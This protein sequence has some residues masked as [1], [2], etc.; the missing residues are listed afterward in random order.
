MPLIL[1]AFPLNQ[2]RLLA[3]ADGLR[4]AVLF[5]LALL[6]IPVLGP[7]GAVAAKITA[8]VA[9]FLLIFLFLLRQ[10]KHLLK[11]E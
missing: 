11:G 3:A 6:L 1:L 8:K 4:A 10:S 2:P 5:A 7:Q 9:G